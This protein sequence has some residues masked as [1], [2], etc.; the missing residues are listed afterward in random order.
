MRKAQKSGQKKI[1]RSKRTKDQK[2]SAF[3]RGKITGEKYFKK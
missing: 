1:G 3:V 2:L